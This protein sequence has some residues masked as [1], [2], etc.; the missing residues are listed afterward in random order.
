MSKSQIYLTKNIRF[1]KIL[2]KVV[3]Y[4]TKSRIRSS[5]SPKLLVK[6]QIVKIILQKMTYKILSLMLII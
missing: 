4:R 2:Y 5:Q 3:F 1:Y 6:G